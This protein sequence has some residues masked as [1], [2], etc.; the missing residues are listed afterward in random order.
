MKKIISVKIALPPADPLTALL[1][2]GECQAV[3]T[4]QYDDGSTG[5]CLKYYADELHFSASD[6]VGKTDD[7]VRALFHQR[8]VA[9]LRS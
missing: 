2:G 8:D 3:V 9:Y 1:S 5:V 7:E 6:F 4:A